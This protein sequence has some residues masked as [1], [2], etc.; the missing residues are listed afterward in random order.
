MEIQQLKYFM[1]LA[2]S[3]NFSAVAKEYFITQPAVS[4]QISKLEDDLKIRLFDRTTHGVRL[5]KAGEEFYRYASQMLNLAERAEQQM[6]SLSQGMEGALRIFAVPSVAYAVSK[7][8]RA[9]HQQYPNVSVELEVGTG[10]QQITEISRESC[11]IYISFYALLE[12]HD[13]LLCISGI[14]DRFSLILPADC[15]EDICPEQ[16]RF[17]A[18]LPL[19]TE[20]PVDAPLLFSQIQNILSE[21]NA[22]P[23]R[24]AFFGNAEAVFLAVEAGLGYSVFPSQTFA[25]QTSA[26]MRV[27]IPGDAALVKNGIAWHRNCKNPSVLHFI[28]IAEQVVAEAQNM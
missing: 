10:S 15:V 21:H 3:L 4:H 2:Q 26:L 25:A 6:L 9:F 17:P 16:F 14:P 1:S 7:L 24:T 28:E 19:L 13:E 27:P 23:I 20:S 18:S 12:R 22:K 8:I 5:T 11:D